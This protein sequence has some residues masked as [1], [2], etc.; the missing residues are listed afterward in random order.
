MPRS[1]TVMMWSKKLRNSGQVLLRGSALF[2]LISLLWTASARGTCSQTGAPLASFDVIHYDLRLEPDIVTKSVKGR[3]MIRLVARAK[4]LDSVEFDCGDLIIGSVRERGESQAFNTRDRRLL[5]T[6]SRPA[7]EGDRRE[8]EVQYHGAPRQGLRFFPDQQQIYTVFSTSHWMVCVDAPHD[9]ATLRMRL[10]LPASL[11]VAAN[12]H[13]AGRRLL[14]DGKVAHEWSQQIP[15]PTY[16]FGFAAG[17]FREI[18]DR[19]GRTRLRHLSAQFSDDELRRIFRDT[20]NMIRYFEERAG[21]RYA[22]ESYTQVL[23]AGSVAQEMSGFSVMGVSYGRGVLANESDVWLGAHELA[24]QWW[25]NMVTCRDWTHFW[26]NEGMATFMAAAFKGDRFGKDEYLR[27]IA[28]FRARYERVRD[29]GKDRSLVFPDW[30]NPTTEDRVLVYFKGAY[31][32]HLLREEM[33]DGPF[34]AAI[35]SYTR[36]FWGKSVTTIDFQRAMETSSGKDLSDFFAKWVYLTK[37]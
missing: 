18:T 37:Q 28:L 25:G 6:L 24:H 9:R 7:R 35:R 33:G 8:I 22:E 2:L 32:L 17:R 13:N 16:T 15:V 11:Q 30:S 4:R 19:S 12:V 34:W 14:K 29:A 26:L 27:E 5:V 1:L 10:V 23:A 3:V 21:V 20:S 31:V 36:A